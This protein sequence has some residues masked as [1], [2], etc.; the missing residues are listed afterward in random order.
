MNSQ[1]L[2]CLTT[3]RTPPERDEDEVAAII[4]DPD[5]ILGLVLQMNR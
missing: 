2:D 5:E 4:D 3:H 1:T